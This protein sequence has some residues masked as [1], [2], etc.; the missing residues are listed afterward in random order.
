MSKKNLILCVVLLSINAVLSAQTMQQAYAKYIKKYSH[1]A[2]EQQKTHNIPASITLAQGLLESAAGESDLA[3]K[4]N[5]HFGIKCSNWQGDKIYADDDRQNECFRKYQTAESSFEDHAN[6]LSSRNRYK[7]LFELAPTDYKAWAYGLRKTGYA[8]DPK[9]AAKLI[10]IIEDYD[11]HKFDVGL[12]ANT[13]KI[14]SKANKKNYVWNAGSPV[15]LAGHN[16]FRNNGVKCIF[17]EPGDTYTSLA[18]EFNMSEKRIL[19]YNELTA[20]KE[21]AP[22]TVVYISRKRKHASAEYKT[23][24]VTAGES[25]YRIA[26]KYA[27]RLQS[28]YDLNDKPYSESAKVGETLKLH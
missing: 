16:I 27:I 8:T 1:I 19:K 12:Q 15:A 21:L 11:L 5:N 3:K 10:R 28:L 17:S 2:V 4:G 6:F 14:N 22:N 18:N 9:Y 13:K 24:I 23:H 25:M 26:Q 20:P 7:A